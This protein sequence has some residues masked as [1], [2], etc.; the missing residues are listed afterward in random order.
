M[1]EDKRN[2]KLLGIF[3]YIMEGLTALFSCLPLIHL[4]IGIAV[5][6][7]GLAKHPGNGP[8]P[9][10]IGWIFI[11]VASFI[12]LTGWTLAVLMIVAGRRL[13][14]FRSRTFCLVVSA[15]SEAWCILR[16]A[17]PRRV[18]DSHPPVLSVASVAEFRMVRNE[19]SR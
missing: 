9:S 2:I 15:P 18:R 1:E 5:L 17:R 6:T 11:L 19:Q 12:I 8:P 13:S 10:L 7:G 3:H 4:F 16:G 14:K